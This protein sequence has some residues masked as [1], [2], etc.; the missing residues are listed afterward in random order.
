MTVSEPDISAKI[1]SSRV[2]AVMAQRPLED[3][4]TSVW[5]LMTDG[6]RF[7]FSWI[8]GGPLPGDCFM[9]RQHEVSWEET[10]RGTL[11]VLLY[12]C[13]SF[14]PSGKKERNRRRMENTWGV[15]ICVY[16]HVYMKECTRH[17]RSKAF[18]CFLVKSTCKGYLF[19]PFF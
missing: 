3:V 16:V 11:S 9:H 19:R 15:S 4:L 1:A 8:Q 13:M 5:V 10:R 18:E 14:S 17:Q 6:R 2:G 12:L 7:Q